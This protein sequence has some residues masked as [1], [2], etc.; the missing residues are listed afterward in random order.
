[1]GG[2]PWCKQE[3]PF[4]LP[5]L[6]S[7]LPRNTGSWGLC[8]ST[9]LCC[10]T[11]GDCGAEGRLAVKVLSVDFCL[12]SLSISNRAVS[13][14]FSSSFSLRFASFS[15]CSCFSMEAITASTISSGSSPNTDSVSPRSV[16]GVG[17][18]CIE[19]SG[20]LGVVGPDGER[21]DGGLLAK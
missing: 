16:P 2:G 9:A 18:S 11:D 12:S 1:M 6:E 7:M 15:S 19:P 5:G 13:L 14:C 8:S 4:R 10:G 21:P 3:G 17:G 20:D